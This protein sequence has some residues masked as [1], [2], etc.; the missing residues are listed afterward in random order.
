[1]SHLRPRTVAVGAVLLAFVGATPAALSAT[2]HGDN[3]KTPTPMCGTKTVA[4]RYKHIV[5]IVFENH[6][7]GEIYGS[8]S[9]PFINGVISA[10]GVAT[11]YH[12][13]THPS[14]PNYLGLTDGGSLRALSLYTSDCPADSCPVLVHSN[15][16]F[17]EVAKRGWKSFEESM[18]S[19]CDRSDSGNYASRHN[20]AVYYT[21]LAK[22][23]SRSDVSLG[24]PTRSALLEAFSAE[25]KAPAFALVTP[26]LCDDMH[27]CSVATGDAWLKTWLPELTASTVYRHADTAIFI[28]WDEG[29]PEHVGEDCVT[30]TSDESCHVMA[31]VVAPSVVPHTMDGTQLDDYSMLKTF[32]RLLGVPELG[33]AKDATSMVK[34]FNL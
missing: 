4:P 22:H 29:E 28:V 14:L 12:N 31:I 30:N 2:R 5:V 10:C 32:E 11:N 15:N 24:T 33:G 7:Y 1:M 8:S 21:D 20:P 34:G 18:P 17:S 27:D 13:L 9:A 25:K 6:S 23:C 19:R 16:I 3:P 26:N